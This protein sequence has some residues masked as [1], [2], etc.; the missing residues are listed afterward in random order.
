MQ[1]EDLVLQGLG[2]DWFFYSLEA[3]VH[4]SSVLLALPSLAALLR[5]PNG[6]FASKF[7]FVPLSFHVHPFLLS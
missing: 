7:K 5:D 6:L 1:V 4:D 2:W 3:S